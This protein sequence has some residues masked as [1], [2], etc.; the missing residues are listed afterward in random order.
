[1]AR[2]KQTAQIRGSASA[3][4]YRAYI[5]GQQATSHSTVNEKTSF[6]NYENIFYSFAFNV[7]SLEQTESFVPRYFVA[8]T[9]ARRW[10]QEDSPPSTSADPVSPPQQSERTYWLGLSTV[11]KHDGEG[12]KNHP[13]L[14]LDLVVSLDI[15]YSMN[16]HFDDDSE[17]YRS[18]LDVAKEGLHAITAQLKSGDRFGLVLFYD[19]QTEILSLTDWDDV[20][21]P[22][23]KNKITNI[24][25]RGGTNLTGGMRAATNL[26]EVSRKGKSKIDPEVLRTRRIIFLTDLNSSCGTANDEDELLKLTAKNASELLGGIYTTV[27]GVGMD[28]NV[29]LVERISKTRGCKYTSITSVSEFREIMDT[30]F[31]HDVMPIAFDIGLKID[32]DNWLVDKAYGSPELN[33]INTGEDDKIAFSSEF[34]SAHDEN[35]YSKGGLILFRLKPASSAAVSSK[36]NKSKGK[37]KPKDSDVDPNVLKICMKYKDV[38]GKECEKSE[39]VRL[40][41]STE[42]HGVATVRLDD[43]SWFHGT[44]VRKAIALVD[45]IDL[46][47]DYIM[48]D[49]NFVDS[50]PAFTHTGWMAP[51]PMIDKIVEL[52]T[53]G[54]NKI[55][56][57]TAGAATPVAGV[58]KNGKAKRGTKRKANAVDG[59]ADS[60]GSMENIRAE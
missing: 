20:N 43:G 55:I 58:T 12:M 3:A 5:T 42:R 10:A 7:G 13:R 52:E 31:N 33:G 16:N 24:Q 59:A 28:F 40:S 48:D 9:F 19:G 57:T 54:A 39:E 50:A 11:S 49:R 53:A 4:G 30:E 41:P 51:I 46:H 36:S 21:K 34:P 2:T 37:S 47:N 56:T 15:S 29:A 22:D 25:F 26:F 18:K 17:T 44:A 60:S 45:F 35:G 23:L 8:S 27:V 32:S 14:P 6:L 1:M 38:A